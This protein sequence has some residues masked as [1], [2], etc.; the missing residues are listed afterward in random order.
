[1]EKTWTCLL[2]GSVRA[3]AVVFPSEMRKLTAVDG[4]S[5]RSGTQIG[6]RT[7]DCGLESIF[8]HNCL[9][10]PGCGQSASEIVCKHW[11]VVENSLLTE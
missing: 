1:M 9:Y 8:C 3:E 4:F 7:L 10:L 2:A 5:T 11:L 6:T